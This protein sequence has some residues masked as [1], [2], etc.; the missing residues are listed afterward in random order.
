MAKAIQILILS[1]FLWHLTDPLGCH[2]HPLPGPEIFHDFYNCSVTVD[3]RR[4]VANECGEGYEV[5]FVNGCS[6]DNLTSYNSNLKT[7]RLPNKIPG[8]CFDY[9][10]CYVR[11]RLRSGPQ[12]DYSAWT[13]LFSSFE[14]VKRNLL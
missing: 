5:Q 6:A 10:Y 14:A 13:T 1:S 8:Q 7:F 9:N 4:Y 3:W 2:L 12:S 11:V